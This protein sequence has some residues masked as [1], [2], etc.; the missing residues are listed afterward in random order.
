V[1]GLPAFVLALASAHGGTGTGGVDPPTSTA[2]G[3]P[4]VSP[5]CRG[6]AVGTVEMSAVSRPVERGPPPPRQL[7]IT[8]PRPRR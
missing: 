8:D 7:L 4:R 2:Q 1:S 3:P 5:P 6:F